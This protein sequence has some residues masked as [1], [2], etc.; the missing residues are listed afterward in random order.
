ME[1]PIISMVGPGGRCC[2]EVR[3]GGA[4]GFL[5]GGMVLVAVARLVWRGPG[6][7]PRPRC[8]REVEPCGISRGRESQG[9]V[10]GEPG[11]RPPVSAAR[12]RP[13]SGQAVGHPT[14]PEGRGLASRF[15]RKQQGQTTAACHRCPG[16]LNKQLGG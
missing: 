14:G 16:S 15:Q 4:C 9:T 13:V 6:S 3:R 12:S 8:P 10:T 7:R 1:S 2:G 11:S 5:S